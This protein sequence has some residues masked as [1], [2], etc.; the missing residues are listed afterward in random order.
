MMCARW[1]S[2]VRTEMKSI[3]AISWFVCP[4]ASSRR[5]SRSRSESGSSLA[6]SAL[7]DLRGNEPRTERRVKVT[8]ACGD[9]LTAPTTSESAAS[10]RT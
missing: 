7:L 4:R 9:L 8:L 6:P 2:A 5:T 1:V 3:F 10:F